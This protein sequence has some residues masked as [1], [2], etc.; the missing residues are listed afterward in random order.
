[1]RDERGEAARRD[2]AQRA[3]GRA[4]PAFLTQL[5]ATRLDLPQHRRLRR[6]GAGEAAASYRARGRAAA[7]APLFHDDRA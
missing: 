4:D 1:M 6:A 3:A 7:M 2:S 5:I